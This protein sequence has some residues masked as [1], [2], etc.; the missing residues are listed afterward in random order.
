MCVRCPSLDAQPRGFQCIRQSVDVSIG[1]LPAPRSVDQR[2]SRGGKDHPPILRVTPGA[3]PWVTWGEFAEPRM[4]AEYRDRRS[5]SGSAQRRKNC[6]RAVHSTPAGK[7]LRAALAT[8]ES[9]RRRGDWSAGMRRRYLHWWRSRLVMPGGSP[10][11]DTRSDEATAA[12]AEL[13]VE[14][15]SRTINPAETV[16]SLTF[17]KAVIAGDDARKRQICE[18]RETTADLLV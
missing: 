14:A 18:E 3:T 17:V 4:L 12:I 16:G 1:L 15:P 13:S 11:R 5:A 2:H 10:A 8:H 6:V 9:V 7:Y